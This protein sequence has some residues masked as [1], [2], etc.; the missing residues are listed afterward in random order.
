M[1]FNSN[2]FDAISG[3]IVFPGQDEQIGSLDDILRGGVVESGCIGR[4][5]PY[6]PKNFSYL[7]G[8]MMDIPFMF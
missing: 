1:I 6:C 2:L 4:P 5:M 7:G 3:R 8:L